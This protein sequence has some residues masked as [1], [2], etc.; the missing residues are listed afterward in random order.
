[1][2]L[3]LWYKINL[4]SGCDG[5]GRQMAAGR[6]VKIRFLKNKAER[7]PGIDMLLLELASRAYPLTGRTALCHLS[8]AVDR[9]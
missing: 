1:M 5:G 7:Y 2:I 9:E 3:I 6:S 4:L 8:P